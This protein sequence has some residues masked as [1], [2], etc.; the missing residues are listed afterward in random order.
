M[1]RGLAPLMEKHFN[2]RIFDE[3]IT[4]AVRL[5]HR[6]IS[7]RQLPDMVDVNYLDRSATTILAGGSGE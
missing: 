7:G 5:S 1:L 4:E 6:Y 3:A 2:I